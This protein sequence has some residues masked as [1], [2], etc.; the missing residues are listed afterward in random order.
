MAGQGFNLVLRDIKKLKE[1]INYYSKLGI[2]IK[3]SYA[4]D[5][6]YDSRKPENTIM[7]L[8]VDAT[9]TFFKK[10]KYLD[11]LKKII[12]KN[13]KNNEILKKI[14]KVISNRGLSL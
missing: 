9:H 14:S 10:N 4:L 12:I 1:I 5:D 11:K 3:N 8:G 2:C 7:S 6:F 13:I